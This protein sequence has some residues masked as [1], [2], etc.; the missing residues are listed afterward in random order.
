VFKQF[1]IVATKC[2]PDCEPESGKQPSTKYKLLRTP[3]LA[4]PTEFS[5]GFLADFRPAIYQ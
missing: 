4:E 3:A 1:W 5:L 2:W